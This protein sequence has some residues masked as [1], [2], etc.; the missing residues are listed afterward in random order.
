MESPASLRLFEGCKFD[1]TT[2]TLTQTSVGGHQE[3]GAVERA[4]EVVQAQLRAYYWT[5][6]NA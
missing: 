4:T 2:T 1:E 6:K 3:I 5:C